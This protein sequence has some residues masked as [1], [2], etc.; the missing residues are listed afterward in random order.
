MLTVFFYPINAD[1][2]IRFKLV[3]LPRMIKSNDISECIMLKILLVQLEE[4]AVG[5]ENEI[6]LNEFLF[7]FLLDHLF[8]PVADTCFM[9]KVERKVFIKK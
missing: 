8:D 5:T 4:I 9:G 2:N 1:I 7:A 6:D 3:R